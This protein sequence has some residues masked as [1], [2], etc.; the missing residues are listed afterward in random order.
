MTNTYYDFFAGPHLVFISSVGPLP[1]GADP[2]AGAAAG[3]DITIA[4]EFVKTI[5][6]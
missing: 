1:A 4:V 6:A 2:F 5:L 3:P